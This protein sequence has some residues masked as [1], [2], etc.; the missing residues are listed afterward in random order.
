MFI[1]Y[2]RDR[3]AARSQNIVDMSNTGYQN[4]ENKKVEGKKKDCNY[5]Q[6]TAHKNVI[7]KEHCLACFLK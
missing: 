2:Y 1:G 6:K 4:R 5:T 7:L 3:K